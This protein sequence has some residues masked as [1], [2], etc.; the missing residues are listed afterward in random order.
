MF[1]GFQR[2]SDLLT[3]KYGGRK[4]SGREKEQEEATPP[5]LILGNLRKSNKFNESDGFLKYNFQAFSIFF[6]CLPRCSEFEVATL[7][8]ISNFK[9]TISNLKFDISKKKYHSKR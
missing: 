1:K 6:K 4:K 7:P 5:I 8:P 2:F 3:Q 9:I